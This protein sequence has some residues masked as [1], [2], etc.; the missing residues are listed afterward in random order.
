MVE[1]PVKSFG[2]QFVARSAA[3]IAAVFAFPLRAA[4]PI[5]D[6]CAAALVISNTFPYLTPLVD[7]ADATTNGDP[8]LPPIGLCRSGPVSR[9]VWYIFTPATT[10]LYTIST[11]TDT[12]TTLPDTVI[13][14]Y[15]AS[16]NC[17]DFTFYECGDDDCDLRAAIETELDAGTTYYIVV[18]N[19]GNFLPPSSGTTV[20]LR[21]SPPPPVPNDTCAGALVIPGT[22]L[23]Y[24]T[25]FSDTR[26]AGKVGDPPAPSCAAPLGLDRSVWF[27][28]QPAVNGRYNFSLC[29]DTATSIY[30]TFLAIYSAPSCAGP[31]TRVACN[32]NACEFKSAITT[33]LTA[34]MIYYIVAWDPDH[35]TG[36]SLIQLRI[37]D[38]APR[39]TAGRRLANGSFELRFGAN[40]T[41]NYTVQAANHLLGVWSNIATLTNGTAV[42]VDTNAAALP[43]RFYRL[44][45]P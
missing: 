24:L 43:W 25:P 40:L 9:S 41:Q 5:N 34:G 27:R 33:D 32:D 3:L 14:I 4:P 11:C 36:E 15:T 26:L 6:T 42:F 12:A 44:R 10:A 38:A 20:Q 30:D 16:G 22:G 39:I 31:F 7:V 17:G 29:T 45:T 8:V 37:A 18:W 2:L 1:I 23:P 35:F 28:F 13:A 21:V 19:N